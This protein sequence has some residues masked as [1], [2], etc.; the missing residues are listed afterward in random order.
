M[1]HFFQLKTKMLIYSIFYLNQKRQ[2]FIQLRTLKIDFFSSDYERLL[3]PL[4]PLPEKQ[5]QIN[6]AIEQEEKITR[7]YEGNKKAFKIGI[8]HNVYNIFLLSF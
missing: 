2:I 1:T 7:R 6:E 3:L 4:S 8:F 5:N